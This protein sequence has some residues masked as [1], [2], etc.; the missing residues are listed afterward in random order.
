VTRTR[1]A[2]T[3]LVLAALLIGGW[4]AG[5]F[6]GVFRCPLARVAENPAWAAAAVGLVLLQSWLGAGMFIVAHDAMHGS[7]A[8]GRPRVNA[9]VGQLALGLYAGFPFREMTAKHHAHHRFSGAAGDPDFHVDAPSGFWRWYAKFFREYWGWPQ[10]GTITGVL[11]IYLLLGAHPLN[12]A[13]FWGLPAIGS[14]LQMFVF[15][16]WLPHR[17]EAG[18]PAFADRHNARTLDWPWLGS[19]LACFHFGLHLEHHHSPAT[20]WWRLPAYRRAAAAAP[21][22]DVRAGFIAR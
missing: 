8:P 18:G 12:A 4:L 17:H 11:L 9:A 13:V 21:G 19:L 7:L 3:G 15:G 6:V 22:V 2:V 16:T 14:S 5:H 20:P 1:Q 10:Q